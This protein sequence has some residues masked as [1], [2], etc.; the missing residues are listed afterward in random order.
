N[1]EHPLFEVWRQLALERDAE[2]VFGHYDQA[3]SEALKA[4][5]GDAYAALMDSKG[6]LAL[7]VRDGDIL[8]VET[9][10]SIASMNKEVEEFEAK[11][12]EMPAIMS[13]TEGNIFK[14]LPLHIRG[15]HLTLGKP[16]ERGFPEVMRTSFTK[17]IFPA[18]QSGRLEFARWLASSEHPLTARVMVNRI[19]RWHFGQGIVSST[20]N[21]G[22]MGSKPSHP[23]L[24]DWLARAFIESGWSIKDMHRLMMKTAVYQQSSRPASGMAGKAEPGLVDPENRL[25]WRANI[26]RL[27]AEEIRDAMLFVSGWLDLAIGGKTIPLRDREFVFNHTSKDATTYESARRA[28]Y[29]PIIRNNLYELLEQFDYPD[30]AISTGNRNS[31]VVAPQALILLNAPVVMQCS[32]RLAAKLAPLAN[33]EERV[34]QAFRLLYGRGPSEGEKRNALDLLAG[35]T[36][37]EKTGRAWAQLCQT[38]LAANEFIYLR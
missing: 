22:V 18:K 32:E 12:P 15:S 3:F 1:P 10:A 13:V 24:L 19:W 20:D 28:L 14:S 16:V 9:L 11:K 8:D 25:L 38:L 21:F 31:S 2:A 5:K 33:D 23:E 34:G 7:P 36:S 35:F 4:K 27:E 37:C 6:F 17:P 30:P 29:L 26:Q